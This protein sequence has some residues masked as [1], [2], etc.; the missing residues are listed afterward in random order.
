MKRM[1]KALLR[2]RGVEGRGYAEKKG[3]LSGWREKGG[4]GRKRKG[5]RKEIKEYSE[6][7]EEGKE[8]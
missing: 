1:V 4:R 2:G 5:K 7:R 6:E 3:Q 8:R